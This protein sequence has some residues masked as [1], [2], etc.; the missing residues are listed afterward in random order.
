MFRES[1]TVSYSCRGKSTTHIQYVNIVAVITARCSAKAP[2]M[3]WPDV[4]LSSVRLT[5]PVLC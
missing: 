1:D 2:T 4:R 3:P 5:T